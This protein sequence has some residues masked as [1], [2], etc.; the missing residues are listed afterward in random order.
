MSRT[1]HGTIARVEGAL[2][3]LTQAGFIAFEIWRTRGHA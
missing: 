1:F 2:L 3:L